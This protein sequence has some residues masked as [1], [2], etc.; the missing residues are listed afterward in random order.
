MEGAQ[1]A[2]D[3]HAD[4]R[5]TEEQVAQITGAKHLRLGF[6]F[7]QP[8][9]SVAADP[10]T[11]EGRYPHPALPRTTHPLVPAGRVCLS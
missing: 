3:L 8:Q 7:I 6:A 1:E 9:C 2:E 11:N 10:I 4:P 5:V